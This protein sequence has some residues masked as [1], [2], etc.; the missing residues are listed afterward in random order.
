MRLS[1]DVAFGEP[2]ERLNEINR[3]RAMND[4]VTADAKRARLEENQ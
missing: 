1:L 3:H 2:S 4:G